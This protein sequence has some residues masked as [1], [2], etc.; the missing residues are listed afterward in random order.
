MNDAPHFYLDILV[1]INHQQLFNKEMSS[2]D[3]LK[4]NEV[5]KTSNNCL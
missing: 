3:I 1:C 5:K 4:I 2:K